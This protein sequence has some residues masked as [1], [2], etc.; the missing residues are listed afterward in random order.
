MSKNNIL[1]V[2][3]MEMSR[4]VTQSVTLQ[5]AGQIADKNRTGAG[6]I[7]GQREVDPDRVTGW[8]QERAQ[9]YQAPPVWTIGHV[10]RRLV[11]G[12]EVLF[13]LPM[14]IA[15]KQYGSAMPAYIHEWSDY[16]A[17]AEG[18]KDLRRA[19]NRLI[20]RHKGATADEVAAM[21]QS[22]AWPLSYLGNDADASRA[23]LLASMWKSLELEFDRRIYQMGMSRRTF[24]RHRKR[25]L[26]SVVSG[27]SNARVVVS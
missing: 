9:R 2:D 24:F 6:L 23:V 5:D 13:R 25:G 19:R 17:Q 22:L 18:E 20:Y 11:Q 7:H 8:W 26:E 27:L 12:F 4:D 15:P 14:R 10:D 16:V 3:K 21:E 1:G